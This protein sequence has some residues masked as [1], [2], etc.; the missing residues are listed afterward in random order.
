MTVSRRGGLRSTKES[1][2]VAGSKAEVSRPSTTTSLP[3]QWIGCA[4]GNTVESFRGR[5]RPS[6]TMKT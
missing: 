4:T 2:L 3:C 6:I 1:G 5:F